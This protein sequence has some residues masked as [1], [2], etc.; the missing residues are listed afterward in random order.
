M[1]ADSDLIGNVED[2]IL[3]TDG[4]NNPFALHMFENFELT[5]EVFLKEQR[6][7]K[8]LRRLKVLL[9][10]RQKLVASALENSSSSSRGEQEEEEGSSTHENPVDAYNQLKRLAF[11]RIRE[12]RLLEENVA[13]AQGLA[14][15]WAASPPPPTPL[16]SEDDATNVTAES[17]KDRHDDEDLPTFRDYVGALNG[18]V[19]LYDTYRFDQDHLVEGRIRIDDFASG[20]DVDMV[21]AH[22][23]TLSD[24]SRM[25]LMAYDKSW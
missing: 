18:M 7:V 10:D 21:A 19:I 25:A 24:Y 14:S 13:S 22:N 2:R 9:E 20:Q 12:L 4:D 5:K 16:S 11:L 15:E 17:K 1:A 23:L 6:L 3:V 8:E